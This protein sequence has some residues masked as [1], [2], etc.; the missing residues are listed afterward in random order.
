M[1]RALGILALAW[2]GFAQAQTPPEATALL[3]K[4]YQATDKLSY[5]GIFVYTQGDK[6]ETSRITRVAGEGGGV[7]RVEVLDGPRREIVRTRDSVRCYLPESHTVKV[8]RN[9]QRAFPA[10][11]PER[12]AELERNYTISRGAHKRIAGFDCES[13]TLTPKDDLR[14]GYRLWAD[15]ASGMLLKAETFNKKGSTVDQFTF[16]QLHIGSVPRE[17]VRTREDARNWRVEDAA[18]TPANLAQSGW[19]VAGDLPGFRKVIEVRRKLGESR[20]A[21]QVVYSDGLAALSVFIEPKSGR[22]EAVRPG[23]STR[24]AFHIYTREVANHIVTVVGE[25]PAASVQR[26][27]NTVVFRPPQ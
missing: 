8:E 4:I 21:G 15:V 1:R 9:D 17:R 13:V 11:L 22:A 10:L 3:R 25:A 5:T 27:A 20:P 18:V 19:I 6:S 12:V 14:Y 2:A 24:G 16:T 23:L 7:E 26:V